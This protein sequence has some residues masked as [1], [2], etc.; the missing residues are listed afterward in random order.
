MFTISIMYTQL[1]YKSTRLFLF[2]SSLLT[3]FNAFAA[4]GTA[5]NFVAAV[6]GSGNPGADA[7]RLLLVWYLP[8]M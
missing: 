5:G 6:A 3:M 8:L 1:H 4:G 7:L 2:S